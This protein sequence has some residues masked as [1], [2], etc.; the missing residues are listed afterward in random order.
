MPAS[1]AV[2]PFRSREGAQSDDAVLGGHVAEA[3]GGAVAT[4]DVQGMVPRR[5]SENIGGSFGIRR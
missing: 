2:E 5:W 1:D 3:W 4:L